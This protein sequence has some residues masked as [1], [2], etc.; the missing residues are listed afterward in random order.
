MASTKKKQYDHQ[1][2]A[3][4][5][6]NYITTLLVTLAFVNEL[7]WKTEEQ[8]LDPEVK[9]EVGRRMKASSKNAVS[10]S[11]ISTPDCVIQASTS[12]LGM[13]AEVTTKLTTDA[14]RWRKK[15]KQVKAYDDDLTGW[16]T[17]NSKIPK[18]DLSLLVHLTRAVD[19]ADIAEEEGK[20]KREI[21]MQSAKAGADRKRDVKAPAKTMSAVDA[22]I[23]F[24]RNFSIVGFQR[25]TGATRESI[26][27][28]K[29]YG[30]ISDTPVAERLRRTVMVPVEV[31]VVE[32]HDKKFVDHEPPEALMLQILWQDLFTSYTE[33][34]QPDQDLGYTPMRLT[35]EGVTDDLRRYYGFSS[36]GEHSPEIP[37]QQ[38]VRKA[39]N[40]LVQIG[41]AHKDG[42]DYIIHFKPIRGDAL[43]RFG[44]LLFEAGATPEVD[45]K[46]LVLPLRTPGATPSSK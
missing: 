37:K 27:L 43:K 16:W 26:T 36:R 11:T 2:V 22:P 5:T 4:D 21:D 42:T 32:Y 15:L 40:R 9:W 6:D 29:E 19:V 46:Q 10:P 23:T 17:A 14:E 34:F 1:R 38:W 31:L 20:R 25:A 24:E 45:D 8:K 33:Q 39:L 35:V 3:E 28:K 30:G 7:R 13:V 41:D 18:H 44:K 12:Q